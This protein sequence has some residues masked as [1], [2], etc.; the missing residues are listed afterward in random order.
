MKLNKIIQSLEEW[1]PSIYQE[2]YDNSGLIIGDINSEVSGCLITLDC[3]EE[4][5]DE[6]IKIAN[7][8]EYG[9]AGYVQGELSHAIEVGNQIRA[10][11]I[12]INGGARGNAAPFGGYKTS[13]NGREHGKH[14]LEE[15]LETKAIIAPEA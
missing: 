14:G 3:T 12:T 11:Q 5:V 13:G 2:S 8:T 6:A 7:D 4:V 15:C 9:L 10:G 1:A